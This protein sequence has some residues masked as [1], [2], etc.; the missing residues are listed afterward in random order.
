MS[1]YGGYHYYRHPSLDPYWTGDEYGW[2]DPS[3]VE[4]TVE[5]DVPYYHPEPPN[6]P[7]PVDYDE[8]DA[9]SYADYYHE[10]EWSDRAYLPGYGVTWIPYDTNA[11][12]QNFRDAITPPYY[13]QPYGYYRESEQVHAPEP[14]QE[15]QDQREEPRIA[16]DPVG[17]LIDLSP[18]SFSA[19]DAPKEVDPI[20]KVVDELWQ[21][22]PILSEVVSAY[23]PPEYPE[24]SKNRRRGVGRIV[25]VTCTRMKRRSA[26]DAGMLELRVGSHF[27]VL[28]DDWIRCTVEVSRND[29]VDQDPVEYAV[30]AYAQ[31]IRRTEDMI[32]SEASRHVSYADTIDY[33]AQGNPNLSWQ[34]RFRR[35]PQ[36]MVRVTKNLATRPENTFSVT[37]LY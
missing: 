27:E 17:D 25:I 24:A 8:P 16:V 15:K 37:T 5:I 22:E 31:A 11:E 2:T 20:S 36:H 12:A 32:A 33:L 1:A 13:Q 35:E 19:S 7:N 14:V 3:D 23:D 18:E 4:P 9:G 26:K 34:P 28:P 29:S 10:P 6:P 30:R 21:P